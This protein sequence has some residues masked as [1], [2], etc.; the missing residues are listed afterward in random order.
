MRPENAP[1]LKGKCAREFVKQTGKPLSKEQL[2][3]F[4]EAD[5]VF[6]AIKQKK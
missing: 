5:R 2:S 6:E 3:I 1:V 4:K